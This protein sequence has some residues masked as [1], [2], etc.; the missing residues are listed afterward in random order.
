MFEM[1]WKPTE[2]VHTRKTG[3]KEQQEYERH[4]NARRNA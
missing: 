3:E 4:E 2:Q 1:K